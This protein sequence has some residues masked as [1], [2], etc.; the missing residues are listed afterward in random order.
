MLVPS[1]S[2]GQP[3]YSLP[4]VPNIGQGVPGI[5][6]AAWIPVMNFPERAAIP[7]NFLL[8]VCAGGNWEMNSFSREGEKKKKK[9]QKEM[10]E[11]G[12]LMPFPLNAG[13]CRAGQ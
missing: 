2:W 13:A 6:P 11:I 12:V 5:N 3:G 7:G 4:T 10:E 8:F 1:E 9:D